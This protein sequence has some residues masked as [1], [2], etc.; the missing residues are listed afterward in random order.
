MFEKKVW[1]IP[2]I[3]LLTGTV[4]F[5]LLVGLVV[6]GIL[7]FEA[8]SA[9]QASIRELKARV[10]EVSAEAEQLGADLE[11]AS[12]EKAQF[13]ED[14]AEK[15]SSQLE[16]LEEKFSSQLEDLEEK[17][18]GQLEGLEKETSNQL[19]ELRERLSLQET[20]V[21]RFQF[22]VLLLKASG[23]ALKARMHLAEKKVGLATRDLR[24]CDSTL[25][26]AKAF[27]DEE[28][29]V[30]LEELRASIRE[31]KESIEAE[32]FPLTTLEILIDRID[33]LIGPG[34]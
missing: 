17:T 21:D 25:E 33:A 20:R 3:W 26:A 9:T 6:E 19:Q 13:Q 34:G 14:L 12:A 16:D 15:F 24:E 10:D 23:K 28:T 7:S 29:R 8:I 18:S 5:L 32:T 11:R 1:K 4:L 22:Q 30:S 31:L 27:A 2:I